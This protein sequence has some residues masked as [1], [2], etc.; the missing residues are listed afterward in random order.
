MLEKQ[1]IKKYWWAIAAGNILA[2]ILGLVS[3]S[4]FT[5]LGPSIQIYMSRDSAS[6]VEIVSLVGAKYFDIIKGFTGLE[7]ISIV[8][9]LKVIPLVIIF[10]AIIRTILTV[11]QWYLWE[12]VSEQIIKDIRLKLAG[13]VIH[14]RQD[15]KNKSIID[16]N[17]SGL[18]SY[19][20]RKT[21]DY[22]VR[23]YG[24]I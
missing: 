9:L 5:L 3:T 19:D 6:E 23:F 11:S 15:N 21:K 18:I 12:F 24:G 16:A 8:I 20:C 7:S 14:S 1:I 2:V 22:F 10:L 17:V 4:L 13:L